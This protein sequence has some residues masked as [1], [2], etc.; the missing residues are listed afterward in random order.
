MYCITVPYLGVGHLHQ[1]TLLVVDEV[2]RKHPAVDGQPLR[3]FH[4]VSQ[5]LA[6]LHYGR[7]GISN[8][9]YTKKINTGGLIT[10]CATT[11]GIL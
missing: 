4:F 9:E 8:L 2:R 11:I 10:N 1:R 6:L 7:P 5:R 3:E